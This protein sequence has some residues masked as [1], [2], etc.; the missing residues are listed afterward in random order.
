M[1][2][3][4]GSGSITSLACFEDVRFPPDSGTLVDVSSA[5][6]SVKLAGV[7]LYPRTQRDTLIPVT[8]SLAAENG[9][10]VG[11]VTR[12]RTKSTSASARFSPCH[13]AFTRARKSRP[14]NHPQLGRTYPVPGIVRPVSAVP[15][16]VAIGA[17][18]TSQKKAN[19]ANDPKRTILPLPRSGLVQDDALPHGR[20]T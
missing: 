1:G 8:H 13:L 6:V 2:A 12:W 17:K 20:C 16:N 18:R 10:P 19:V 4:V 3:N 14:C 9:V 5:F 11:M 7:A 15:S